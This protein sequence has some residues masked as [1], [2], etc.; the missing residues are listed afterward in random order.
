MCRKCLDEIIYRSFVLVFNLH[1]ANE[2]TEGKQEWRTAALQS[3]HQDWNL[4]HLLVILDSESY[5]C[6]ISRMNN[7][8]RFIMRRQIAWLGL[9][10]NMHWENMYLLPKARHSPSIVPIYVAYI[11]MLNMASSIQLFSLQTLNSCH[12]SPISQ[13]SIK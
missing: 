4:S 2:M 11:Y 5:F 9:A 12:P 10:V 3:T 1:S 8:I 13:P 7:D 6:N